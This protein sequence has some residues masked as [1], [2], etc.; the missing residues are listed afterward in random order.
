MEEGCK[1]IK[2]AWDIFNQRTQTM[3]PLVGPD[4]SETQDN[5]WYVPPRWGG[6]PCITCGPEL[7]SII[8]IAMNFNSIIFKLF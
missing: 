4:I 1:R 7:L 5:L 8:S 3:A 6:H 2:M